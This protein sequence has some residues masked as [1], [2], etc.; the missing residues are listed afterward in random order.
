[1]N[2]NYLGGEMKNN[3]PRIIF[4]FCLS[5]CFIVPSSQMVYA[6]P[7]DTV[8]ISV[9]SD[10][11]QGSGGSYPT[12]SAD[13]RF[14]AFSS[15]SNTLILG[16]TNN[17]GDIFLRDTYLGT[18][19]RISTTSN[20]VEANGSSG[21]PSISADGTYVAFL[22]DATNLVAGDTNYSDIFVKNTQTGAIIRAS[23]S[24]NETQANNHSWNPAISADGRFVAFIS[25]AT[26]LVVG[27]INNKRDI[28][29][30]DLQINTTTRVSVASDGTEANDHSYDAISYPPSI[31][32]N[33]RYVAF[34]SNA[35]NLVPNDTN[36]V[37]DIFV[38]DTLNQR[39]K[40]ISIASDGT[41]ANS[42]SSYPFISANGRYVG[43]SSGATTLT[44]GDT[45]G[46]G[47]VF[48]HDLLT[49]ITELVSVSSDETQGVSG[50]SHNPTISKDGR[51]IA[52]VS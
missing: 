13:G 14:I 32:E 10:G 25:D 16:D 8:L 6:A 11:T 45:N 17:A 15:G 21:N 42:V 44:N 36:G 24:V 41:E 46:Y 37:R 7:G 20:E 30:R 43:F 27:D 2:N 47:D 23:V 4:S 52:F 51:Y 35:S 22:S 33:G 1:M 3:I 34:A 28:F 29:V 18:T 48:I 31:S 26:N 40:R 5:I 39:T 19:I 12:I 38:H 49:G 9:S 50:N